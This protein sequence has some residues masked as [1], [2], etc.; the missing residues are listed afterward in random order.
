MIGRT[1]E[2]SEGFRDIETYRLEHI[3]SEPTAI[4]NQDGW[5]TLNVFYGS[6]N[7]FE[8]LLPTDQKFY[9]QARQDEVILSL[10]KNKTKGYF[11]DLAANDATTLSNSYALERFFGW[12]GLCIEPNPEYWYSLTHA[13]KNCQLVG[14]VVGRKRMEQVDFRFDGLEHG[15]IVGEGFDNG[16]RL[17]RYS[18]KEYTV[19][20]FEIFQKFDVPK[21]IDYMSLDIEGAEEF[22]MEDFPFTEYL[23]RILTIERPTNT[24]R[25]YLESHGY[26]QILR[27]SFWGETLWIHGSFEAEMDMTHLQDFHGKKQRA[28]QKARQQQSSSV[29]TN[30]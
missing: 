29:A 25:T 30:A 9:S 10:L 15:G 24:L 18:T 11:V 20:L 28:E 13:R 4:D 19:S 12:R 8:S 17:K 5:K 14:A 2:K 16:S 27:L 6:T 7:Y 3:R 23:I 22:I 1:L 21:V 26:K